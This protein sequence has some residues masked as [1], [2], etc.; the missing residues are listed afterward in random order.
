[1]AVVKDHT[2][3]FLMRLLGE[4]ARPSENRLRLQCFGHRH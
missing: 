1:M 2:S 3:E 4:S